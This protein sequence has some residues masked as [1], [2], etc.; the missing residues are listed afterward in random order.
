MR[1]VPTGRSEMSESPGPAD[2]YL[3]HGLAHVSGWLKAESARV[4]RALQQVQ[5]EN[6]VR[7]N[8]AEIGVHHGKLFLLLAG[9][10]HDGEEAVALDVFG[11]QQKN[12]DRSGKGDRAVFERNLETWAPGAAVRIVQASSLEVA[13]ET[14]RETFGDVRMISIDG[15]HTA[16]VAEHDLWLAQ[17]CLVE[18]GIVIL[19]D[20]LN[21][22]WLGVVTGL[23]AYLSGGGTLRA[24]AYSENKL[25]LTSGDAW[26]DTYRRLLRAR[27]PRLFGKADVDFLG[28]TI[29][30]YGQ[31]S[32]RR[33]KQDRAAA[34]TAERL[35]E[36]QRTI[37]RLRRRIATMEASTSWRVTAGPRR[38]AARLRGG[39]TT[40]PK[41]GTR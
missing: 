26:V 4:V 35:R 18:G 1:M 13:P 11:D 15:G 21:P 29:D 20:L 34:G 33:R 16:E 27:V 37:R 8:V 12:L 19:D 6:G 39:S 14:A 38:L 17:A 28:A 3:A 41:R 31:G 32:A 9:D 36:Q 30:V 40:D 5:D 2:R 24:F 22:H 25:Y 7:G 10:L 23:A